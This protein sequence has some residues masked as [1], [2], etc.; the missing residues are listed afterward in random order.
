MRAEGKSQYSHSLIKEFQI[1]LPADP[2]S[3]VV[4]NPYAVSWLLV[5]ANKRAP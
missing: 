3:G 4:E 2:S 1:D 5:L